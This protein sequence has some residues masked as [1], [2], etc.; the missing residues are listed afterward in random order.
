MLSSTQEMSMVTKK[1][2]AK[3]LIHTGEVEIQIEFSRQNLCKAS[4]FEPYA[5]FQRID[6]AGKGFLSPKDIFNFIK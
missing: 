1:K 4:A 5:A 3:L 6:R 2:L